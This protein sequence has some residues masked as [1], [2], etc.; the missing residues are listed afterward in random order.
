M[1]SRN[2]SSSVLQKLNIDNLLLQ[3]NDF[4]LSANNSFYLRS[5]SATQT[6]ANQTTIT[7]NNF[8]G[9]LAITIYDWIGGAP[10]STSNDRLEF[11]E[12]ILTGLAGAA[13]SVGVTFWVNELELN[14][15]HFNQFNDKVFQL[16]GLSNSLLHDGANSLILGDNAQNRAYSRNY[17]ILQLS[18]LLQ[19]FGVD[20]TI[21]TSS[22]KQSLES[23]TQRGL[24]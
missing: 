20:G 12:N 6:R 13:K 19:I 23:T 1:C 3:G 22:D 4:N 10:V 17:E 18:I 8:I 2:G 15:N 14:A 9:G 21:L 5:V 16:Y 24:L 11:S 7:A